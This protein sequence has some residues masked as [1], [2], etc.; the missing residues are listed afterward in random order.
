MED[1]Y[2]M[3]SAN[4]CPNFWTVKMGK[5][6]CSA[7]QWSEPKEWGSITAKLNGERIKPTEPREIANYYDPLEGHEF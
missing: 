3:C 5:P 7:H 1:D 4:G 6:L 2:L